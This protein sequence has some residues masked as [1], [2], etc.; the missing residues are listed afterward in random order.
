MIR[1]ALSVILAACAVLFSESAEGA[2]NTRSGDRSFCISS[3]DAPADSGFTYDPRFDRLIDAYASQNNIDPFLIRCVIK[4]ESDY[5]PNAV[6]VAGAAGL[7]QLM[8]EVAREYGVHDRT[9][10]ESNI[11]AGVR[12]LS[13][14]LSRFHGDVS[15]ALAA[16]HAGSSRVKKNLSVPQIE[17]TKAYVNLI[18]FYYTG[19]SDYIHRYNKMLRSVDY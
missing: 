15:L 6:S 16:Y 10:P 2:K 5:N 9:D 14:L 3:P 11:K 1:A 4:V 7:M 13:Y 8:Q 12:H 19:Q 18:M 17:S